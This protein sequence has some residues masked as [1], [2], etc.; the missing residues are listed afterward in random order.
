M[1]SLHDTFDE[2]DPYADLP[3]LCPIIDGAEHV[4]ETSSKHAHANLRAAQHTLAN[5]VTALED[6]TINK[7]GTREDAIQRAQAY[8]HHAVDALDTSR[9]MAQ[10]ELSSAR[11]SDSPIE[12]H[13]TEALTRAETAYNR[14]IAATD[15][16]AIE[17]TYDLLVDART[18]TERAQTQLTA[19]LNH[20]TYRDCEST[21]VWDD[22]EHGTDNGEGITIEG[23]CLLCGKEF[24][25]V[26]E[27]SGVFDQDA[28]EHGEY[29]FRR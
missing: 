18:F 3:T 8:L 28:D 16:T 9:A 25:Q 12:H 15:A 19:L 26:F 1:T 23:Y 10:D 17:Q 20:E 4:K 11:N 21:I 24:E 7:T 6:S 14:L 29:V 22:L 27:F 13:L 5:I 2:F